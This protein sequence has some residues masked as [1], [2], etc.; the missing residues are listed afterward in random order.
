FGGG[1][2]GPDPSDLFG[3]D[4]FDM[5]S[6]RLGQRGFPEAPP[7]YQVASAPD[8]VAFLR[9]L[10][11]KKSV[12]HGE[13]V[14]LTVLAYG[15]RGN[16]REVSPN[17]PSFPDFLSYSVIETSHDEPTY[18]TSIAGQDFIVRKLR[19]YILVPLR[20][21]DLAI[22]GMA[23]VLQGMRGGYPTQN[24]PLG[25]K[26]QSADLH[27][28]VVDTPAAGRPTGY[29]PGDVG[30]YR[31]SADVSPRTLTEGDFVEVVV[32]IAGL[33]QIPTKV[34][35]PESKELTWESPKMTGGPAVRDG[36]L[37]GTRVLKYALQV[38]TSGQVQLGEVTLPYFDHKKRAYQVAR[39]DLGVVTVDASKVTQANHDPQGSASP[40]GS[41]PSED[42]GLGVP[43]RPRAN[44]R[45]Y[46]NPAPYSPPSL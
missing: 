39:A 46:E 8:S 34:L 20:T 6:R 24:S 32:Q 28:N 3:D 19:E 36:E 43:L 35:L 25:M 44:L 27:L 10:V 13:P 18:Q 14:R 40:N 11:N 42:D 33:G 7:E 15:S 4:P 31:L 9:L 45:P 26:I 17:E 16:F 5:L 21:G 30:S 22:G 38:K 1:I 12:G 2:F 41:V 29:F 37:Q 23:A